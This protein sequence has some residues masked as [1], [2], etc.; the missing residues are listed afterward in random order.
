MQPVAVVI[1]GPVGAGKTTT[2]Q[3]L[4]EELARQGETV[5]ALDLDNLR[6]LWPDDSNDPFHTQLGLT[7]LSAIWPQFAER[8]AR[9]LLLT[10]IVEHP[11]QRTDYE[12]ALPGAQ[13]VVVRLDVPLDRL[14]ERLRRRESGE[15]LTWHLH[16]SVELHQLMTERGVG[17]IVITVDGE[18]PQ[19]VATLMLEKIQQSGSQT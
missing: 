1:T 16:R 10:D 9:W 2:M 14:H 5:A 6:A 17:D 4:A 12:A 11:D 3:V 18:D 19:Q 13:I 15:S 7:N 8:G